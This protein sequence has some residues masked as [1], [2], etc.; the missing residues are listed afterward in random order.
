MSLLPQ[1]KLLQSGVTTLNDSELI[2]LILRTGSQKSNIFTLSEHIMCLLKE[3]IRHITLEKL[4]KIHGIG[5]VKACQILAIIEISK[6]YL[7]SLQTQQILEAKD[8]FEILHDLR[9]ASQEHVVVIT[10]NSNNN[11]IQKHIISKGTINTSIVHPRE[12]LYPAICDQA[13]SIVMAHNHPSGNPH[14]SDADILLTR[15]IYNICNTFCIPLEDHVIIAKDRFV[16]LK[17]TTDI[18]E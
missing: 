14:P 4:K 16:S 12:I 17:A 5:T 8:V 9:Y 7:G 13:A 11:I 10:L 3:D 6:R 1:E 2:A 15:D 18:F